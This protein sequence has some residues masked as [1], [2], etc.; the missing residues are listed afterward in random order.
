[1]WQGPNASIWEYLAQRSGLCYVFSFVRI[2][3]L[4]QSAFLI[5]EVEA[6]FT[7]TLKGR[8][9]LRAEAALGAIPHLRRNQPPL[10]LTIWNTHWTL[11]LCIPALLQYLYMVLERPQFEEDKNEGFSIARSSQFI[12]MCVHYMTFFFSTSFNS[13]MLF[14]QVKNHS[15]SHTSRLFNVCSFVVHPKKRD[16]C[17]LW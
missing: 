6:D 9:F 7:N 5:L 3:V 11:M 14:S 1:M 2:G 12:L 8:P 4:N 15:R 13:L 16:I 10:T 17:S